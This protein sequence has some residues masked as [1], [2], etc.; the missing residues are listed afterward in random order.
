M[1]DID[2]RDFYHRYIAVLNAHRFDRMDQFINDEVTL[3]SEPASRDVLLA[4]PKQ[5][6]NRMRSRSWTGSCPGKTKTR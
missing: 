2:L 5:V 3:N 1:S 6:P 4:G